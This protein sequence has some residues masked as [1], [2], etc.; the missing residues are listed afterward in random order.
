MT[1]L[2]R[3]QSEWGSWHGQTMAELRMLA[4]A[5]ESPE[6][7]IEEAN[8]IIGRAKVLEA[9]AFKRKTEALAGIGHCLN[10]ARDQYG[11]ALV[12]ALRVAPHAVQRVAKKKIAEAL[13]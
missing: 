10:W 9:E 8:A 11:D 7:S 13:L 4:R 6:L 12:K 3:E 2:R 5:L 1:A